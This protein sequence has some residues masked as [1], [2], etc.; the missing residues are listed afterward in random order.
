MSE[1]T[2]VIIAILSSALGGMAA[3]VTRYLTTS[4][5]PVTLAILRLGIGFVCI[6]PA[7]LAFRVRWPGR[8]DLPAV[9]AFGMCFFGLFFAFYNVALGYTTAARASLALSTLP[10]Q[11]MAVG[12][13][14]NIELMTARNTNL[15]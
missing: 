8:A 1:V 13:L 9:I 14:L 4:A 6:L 2:G 11:T 3:A 7:A 10:L 5:N 15:Q 12:A